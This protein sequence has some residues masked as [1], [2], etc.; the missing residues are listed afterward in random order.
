MPINVNEN[1]SCESHYKPQVPPHQWKGN[2]ISE[3]TGW[4]PCT[5]AYS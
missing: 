2:T 1:H 4:A 5:Q 3:V